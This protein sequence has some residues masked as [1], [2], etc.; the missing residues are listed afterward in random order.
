MVELY[1]DCDLLDVIVEEDLRQILI[2]VSNLLGVA[3][4][5][6]RVDIISVDNC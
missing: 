1:M 3:H 6:S 2:M 4:T 5:V